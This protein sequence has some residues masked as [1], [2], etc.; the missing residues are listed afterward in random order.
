MTDGEL[1]ATYMLEAGMVGF[2]GSLIGT[3]VA[4]AINVPMVKYGIDY[5][6][7]L[8]AMGGD[9]GYRVNGLFRSAWN[10]PVIVGTGVAAMVISA[11][12]A[13]FPTKRAL[14]MPIT[15]S[16]RFE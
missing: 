16:L 6:A 13:Y 2:F 14:K 4:C 9:M 1:I 11:V 10:V 3:I 5:S 15:D 12:T 7:A 8:E